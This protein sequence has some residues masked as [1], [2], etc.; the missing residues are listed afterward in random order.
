MAAPQQQTTPA[1]D[2]N[3][4]RQ[5]GYSDDEILDHLTQTA[6]GF[7]VGAALKAGHSKSDIIDY[8]STTPKA[9]PPPSSV[10]APAP[11][12]AP[13][14]QAPQ[15]WGSRILST[16]GGMRSPAHTLNPSDA[17]N[18]VLAGAAK[19]GVQ[20]V[21]PALAAG[22]NLAAAATGQPSVLPWH[23]PP[24]LEPQGT[25]ERVGAGLEQGLEMAATGGPLRAGAEAL[26]AKFPGIVKLAGLGKATVPLLRTGAEAL[27]AAGSAGVHGQ[28]IGT[29]AALGAGGAAV[30]EAASALAPKI[31]E[32]ALRVTD[33]I[34]GTGKTVGQTALEETSGIGAATIAQQ[35]KDQSFAL[36]NQMEQAVHDATTAGKVGTTQP[37]HAAL[38]NAIDNTPRNAAG[39]RNK[40][41][42]LHDLLD[43]DKAGVAR[44]AH[45]PDE[46]LEMKRG[47]GTEIETWPPEWQQLNEVKTLK[48]QLYGAIDSE[49]DRLV[50]GNAEINDRISNLIETKKR[51]LQVA[52]GASIGQRVFAR[53]AAHTGA[54][55]LGGLGAAGGY[56]KHGLPGAA[57]GMGLGV[58]GPEIAA[59]P[60][61]QMALARLLRLGIPTA[62]ARGAV[63][64]Q[65][66]RPGAAGQMQRSMAPTPDTHVFHADTWKAAHPG[67]DVNPAIQAARASG[68]DIAG[69]PASIQ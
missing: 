10:P 50:P 6:S 20:T 13:A 67:Q 52:S 25:Q 46:L 17:Q 34:R 19:S 36:R 14:P 63:A 8:L 59:S 26:A 56:Q 47:I 53:G 42:G 33:R 65:A 23:Q 66:Q 4:A 22:S 64:S 62:L 44:A 28:P 39:L 45:T 5:A 24:E 37:A 21:Y 11:P 54:L 38:Q 32:S 1:F 9:T 68:Y 3:A 29:S 2:V 60:T 15:S 61:G 12:P 58:L 27:N 51:A 7:D 31:A 49:L 16:L 30:G 43:L 41:A 69:A 35:A 55:A 40:L 18:P 57:V 48:E